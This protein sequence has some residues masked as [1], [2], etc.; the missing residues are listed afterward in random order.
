[1]YNILSKMNIKTGDVTLLHRMKTLAEE[2]TIEINGDTSKG[3]KEFDVK[4]KTMAPAEA[5]TTTDVNIQ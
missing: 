2:G 4:L 5:E 3:W 1:M